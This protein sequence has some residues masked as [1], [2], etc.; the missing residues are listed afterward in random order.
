MMSLSWYLTYLLAARFI[1]C[2]SEHW[3][4]RRSELIAASVLLYNST[5]SKVGHC[6]ISAPMGNYF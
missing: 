5:H 6:P 4:S 3:L 1:D 2:F